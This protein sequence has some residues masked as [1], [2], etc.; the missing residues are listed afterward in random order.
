MGNEQSLAAVESINPVEGIDSDAI[1]AM[2]RNALESRDE[3][4]KTDTPEKL[5]AEKERKTE[6]NEAVESTK[7]ELIIHYS[8]QE[9]EFGPHKGTIAVIVEV[10]PP[11]KAM[12]A[13]GAGLI[14]SWIDEYKVD[15]PKEPELPKDDEK[16]HEEAPDEQK[17]DRRPDD[18]NQARTEKPAVEDKMKKSTKAVPEAK[19]KEVSVEKVSGDALVVVDMGS[20]EAIVGP[21][22]VES[23]AHL[24]E[25]ILPAKEAD[26]A[27][28]ETPNTPAVEVTVEL[29][30]DESAIDSE[31]PDEEIIDPIEES[32]IDIEDETEVVD[33]QSDVLEMVLASAMNSDEDEQ[34]GYEDSEEADEKLDLERRVIAIPYV[35]KLEDWREL[36]KSDAPLEMS[37]SKMIDQMA[38][39]ITSIANDEEVIEHEGL[40]VLQHSV[41]RVTESLDLLYQAKS[42]EECKERIED[43]IR[44]MTEL[45]L[46]LGYDNPE[47]IIREFM[48]HH[49]IE[50]LRELMNYLEH[51]VTLRI[52]RQKSVPIARVS[53]S[54]IHL[55]RM[56]M[57][58]VTKLLHTPEPQL[59]S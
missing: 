28:S 5:A 57:H 52:D 46:L 9:F 42:A 6:V 1:N 53:R 21:S 44:A 18:S 59:I 3:A 12:L 55:G 35:E 22:P 11:I 4:K 14:I 2:L 17:A 20:G 54:P 48:K 34:E 23:D 49:S 29:K 32:A 37:L 19:P 10:C 25:V 40:Q 31:P 56:A 15:V 13:D 58:L 39:E 33:G 8:S 26:V 30:A 7:D 41:W 16:T 51:N 47:L 24:V 45:L 27:E 50:S 36:G 43:V 38:A